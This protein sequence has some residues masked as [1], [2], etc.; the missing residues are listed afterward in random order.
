L[1]RPDQFV[2]ADI[3]QHAIENARVGFL[4]G[5]RATGDSFPIT[6]AV[7][8]ERGGVG[9]ARQRRDF[10]PRRIRRRQNLLCLARHGDK[11][12]DRI[13]VRALPSLVE[14]VA[15]HGDAAFG[16]EFRQNILDAG[17]AAKAFGFQRRAE[18]PVIDRRVH[19]AV[20]RLGRQ[21][22]R[23]A[24]G[25]RCLRFQVDAVLLQSGLQ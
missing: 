5:D 2:A 6:I 1:A 24:V 15:D 7:D 16:A 14:D 25:D 19:F 9:G 10:L 21:Q 4:V 3:S 12:G 13:P 23:R 22:R 8:L 20:E 18:I 17:D 11:T